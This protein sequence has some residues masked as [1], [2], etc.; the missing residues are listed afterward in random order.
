ME[1]IFYDTKLI[2]RSDWGNIILHY[3]FLAKWI[4]VIIL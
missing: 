1:T 2:Q 4:R 3:L